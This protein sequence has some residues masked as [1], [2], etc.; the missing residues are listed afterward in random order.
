[1]ISEDTL[2]KIIA[3]F[4]GTLG[5]IHF[6]FGKTVNKYAIEADLLNANVAVKMSG[7][8]LMISSAALFVPDYAERGFYGLCLFLVASSI[9]L[10]KFW[11]KST[12]LEQLVEF[13]HF[14]KNLLLAVLLWYLKNKLTK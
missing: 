8:L 6:I 14:V 3:I 1:M 13:L 11:A 9:V 12:A 5:L 2:L 7:M 10:H 4:F